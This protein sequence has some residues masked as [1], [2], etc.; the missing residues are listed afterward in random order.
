MKHLISWVL[1]GG[2]PLSLSGE[3]RPVARRC[4]AHFRFYAK[5]INLN[6]QLDQKGRRRLTDPQSHS[7]VQLSIYQRT[8]QQIDE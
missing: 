5:A 1:M 8:M 7:L 3:K 2:R 6:K 4:L